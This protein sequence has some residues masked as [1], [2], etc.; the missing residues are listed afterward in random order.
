[1]A[2]FSSLNV[3]LQAMMT[4]QTAIQVIE[5]N[6]ANASTPG[7]RRQQ[8]VIVSAPPAMINNLRAS[9]SGSIGSG[10]MVQ[11]IM[12]YG[13]EFFDTRFR[14]ENAE[15]KR[16]A[17][18]RDILQQTEMILG[19]NT[20]SGLLPTLDAFFSSW[21]ALSADPSNMALRESLRDQASMVATAFS[22]RA[23]DIK[24]LQG[25]QDLTIQT[26][27]E[28]VNSLAASVAS[29][30]S[31]IST[32]LGMGDQPNDLMD[33][34]DRL[35]D[36]LSEITGATSHLQEDGQVIVSINGHWL[37]TGTQTFELQT[38]RDS[39]NLLNVQWA[40]N[41]PP[42]VSFSPVTGEL[43]GLFDARDGVL[44]DQLNR[45]NALATQFITQVNA[46]HQAGYVLNGAS[47]APAMFTGT[48]AFSIKV[49]DATPPPPSLSDVANI[50]AALTANAIGDGT[51]AAL[52]AKLKDQLFMSGGTQTFNAFYSGQV[53][54][55]GLAV[56]KADALATDRKYVADAWKTQRESESGVNLD[57]EAASLVKFQRSYQAAA[58]MITVVDDLLDRVINGMIR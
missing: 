5:H 38:Y 37:V 27:V 49:N 45:L 18:T 33:E 3:I 50:G 25:D 51:N 20:T 47:H 48:D 12:R 35:L 4:N 57:E 2:T 26:R 40:D 24:R 58:K 10:S 43:R 54:S 1:M 11:K 6:V 23:T 15:A 41:P 44:Q 28:E 42:P 13:N 30:N 39:N 36:R 32:A 16:Y 8:A 34:R 53:A 22:T 52:M 31:R 7:Y 55:L 21:Q 19:E 29:L 46:Q 14:K 9:G 56:R 17:I